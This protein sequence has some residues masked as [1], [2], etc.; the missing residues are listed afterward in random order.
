MNRNRML[1]VAVLSFSLISLE[2]AWTRIFS[3]EFFYTFAFLVLSLAVAGLGL[4]ALSLR[5]FKKLDNLN[6][7]GW[8][9]SL[10]GLAAL[11]GPPLVFRL[12]LDFSVLFFDIFMVGKLFLTLIIL[13]STFFFGGMTLG[14]IFKNK[15][16][17]MPYLYMGDL[18]GAGFGVIFSIVL[19]NILGTPI[20]VVVSSLP[21]FLL[22]ILHIRGLRKILPLSAILL[23]C[24]IGYYADDILEVPREEKIPVIYKHWDAMSKIKIYDYGEEYRRINIDNAANTGVNGFDG[25]WD[26]P[27]SLKFGFHI[28]AYL[29]SKFDSC[30]FLSLGAGGGQDVFQALQDGATEI[31]AVEVIAHL[32]HLLLEGDLAEFS[33]NIY[34]DNR[35]IV[36]SEDARSYV[37][38]FDG[39]FDLIYSFSSNSFAALA[40]GAFALAENYIYTTEAFMDY[41]HALSHKGYLLMEHQAFMPRLVSAVMEALQRLGV[42]SPQS[43]IAVY[44]LKNSSRKMLLLSKKPLTQDLLDEAWGEYA[45]K[46]FRYAEMLYPAPD[47]LK[48]NR[49]NQQI[50]RG[51]RAMADSSKLN[52]EPSD[53]DRPFIAQMGLWDNLDFSKIKRIAGYSD[54]LGFP[55]SR[56]IVVIILFAVFLFITPLNLLPYFYSGEKLRMIP[57][58]YFFTIGMAFMGLEII[59]IQKY[60]LLIGPSVYS[61]ITILFT[62]LISSGI[63]SRFSKKTDENLVFSFIIFWILLD[64]F[65]LTKMMYWFGD[66]ELWSRIIL[67]VIFVAPLGFFMGMPFPKAALRVGNLVDWGFAVNGT[68]SIFGSTLAVFVAFTLGFNFMMIIC[69]LLYLVAYFMYVFKMAWE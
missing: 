59:L 25:N 58:L 45:R 2:M 13:N 24:I 32:N 67:V 31:H 18:I 35:V 38:R 22:A 48:D 1:T 69:L 42:E 36:V 46:D 52:L 53:D 23:L 5:L 68:A 64:I 63:G 51:W 54:W 27:D 60:T 20:T 28:V 33:G 8:M 49:Y 40:S 37:R 50:E 14:L 41:W 19:M 30:T 39:K 62:L 15:P 47:S 43:H 12:G 44:A 3:A 55:L 4:G 56:L 29:I 61:I 10:S 6:N 7:L 16:Q 26:R 11:I 57:W 21:L 65:F 17:E 66:L 34:N 9:L